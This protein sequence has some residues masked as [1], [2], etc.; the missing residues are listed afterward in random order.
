VNRWAFVL[1]VAGLTLTTGC[2]HRVLRTGL[3]VWQLRGAVV[4]VSDTLLQVRHKT[5]GI[6]DLRLDDGTTFIKD[7]RPDSRQSLLRGS[8]VTVDVETIQRG[9][10]RARLVQIFG[11]GRPW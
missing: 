3:Y 6:V 2:A 10:Y 4:S 5:G 11:G 9:V 7:K 8:R 1:I